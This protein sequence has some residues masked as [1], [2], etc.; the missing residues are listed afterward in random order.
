MMVLLSLLGCYGAKTEDTAML[1]VYNIF[2]SIMSVAL[3]GTGAIGLS[4][5]DALNHVA[6]VF[7]NGVAELPDTV[8]GRLA[9]RLNDGQIAY[10]ERCCGSYYPNFAQG[11]NMTACGAA[12]HTPKSACL[13]DFAFF[14]DVRSSITQEACL[15]GENIS[16]EG[17]PLVGNPLGGA[18]TCSGTDPLS[19]LPAVWNF[20]RGATAVARGYLESVSVA[21]VVLGVLLLIAAIFA[22]Y[23]GCSKQEEL[24]REGQISENVEMVKLTGFS[25]AKSG[26]VLSSNDGGDMDSAPSTG[27]VT[28]V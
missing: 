28:S 12:A 23:M 22:C 14:N 10:F 16:F 15:A 7:L 1:L 6:D 5:T 18:S 11:A 4:Q 8:S 2:V 13:F 3:I 9:E 27:P 25:S 21:L 19:G 17:A 26:L 20:Q 24:R